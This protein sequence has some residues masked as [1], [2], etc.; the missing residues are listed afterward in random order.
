MDTLLIAS[1]ILFILSIICF[2]IKN[3]IQQLT[4][5]QTFQLSG[6]KLGSSK[7]GSLIIISTFSDLLLMASVIALIIYF[8]Y[9]ALIEI[10]GGLFIIFIQKVMILL[11][12]KV[13]HLFAR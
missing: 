9:P 4:L 11:L 12:Q 13:I 1:I 6:R 8:D 10:L 3:G 7:Y 5:K 2:F